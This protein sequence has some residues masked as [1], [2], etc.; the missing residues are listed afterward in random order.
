MPPRKR[1][2]FS[3]LGSRYEI[4]ESSTARSTGD[5]GIDYGF[6][7]TLDAEARRQGVGEVGYG[8]RDAWADPA[9]T[10]LEIAPMTVGEMQQTEI[11]EL[12]ETDCRR[13]GQMVETLRV[14]G[15]MRR[16]MEEDP[17]EYEDDET[18]DGPV[19]YPMDGG[20]DG[21]DDNGESSGD[22]ADDEDEDEEEEHFVP[23]DSAIVIPTNE[24]AA[25]SLPLEAEVERLL[26]MPTL[27]PS[28]LVS[29]SPPSSR[30]RLARIGL[31]NGSYK[32]GNLRFGGK[33]RHNNGL[34]LGR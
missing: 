14:M 20:D 22:D 11:S 34:S 3:T 18:E 28:P 21:D 13:Q 6:V 12:R 33:N 27:P 2:C 9:E 5:R 26:V 7:S 23:A 25:I 10:V 30:E 8:I 1:L 16:E 15:D 32:K 4:R 24:L 31:P 17:E 29:L 19:D